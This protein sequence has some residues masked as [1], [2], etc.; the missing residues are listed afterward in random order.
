MKALRKGIWLALIGM[1]SIEAGTMLGV[2]ALY[3]CAGAG[4]YL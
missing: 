1:M 3:L 2:L 4:Y